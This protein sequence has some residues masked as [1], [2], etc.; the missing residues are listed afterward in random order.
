MWR[1]IKWLI[2]LAIIGSIGLIAY[3]YVGPFFGA[4]FS[5]VQAEIRQTVILNAD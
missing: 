3:T 1:I 2:Y 4:D 5:P